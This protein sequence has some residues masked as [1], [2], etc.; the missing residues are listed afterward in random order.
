M[1]NYLKA[2]FV[3]FLFACYKNNRIK[4]EMQMLLYLFCIQMN[5]HHSEMGE[6]CLLIFSTNFVPAASVI[7]KHITRQLEAGWS[8]CCITAA[9]FNSTETI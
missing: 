8:C 7:F 6:M 3:L 5:R 1:G 2:T 4:L 9:F